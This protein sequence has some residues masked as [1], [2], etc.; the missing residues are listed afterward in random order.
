MKRTSLGDLLKEHEVGKVE[1]E[2]KVEV[3]NRFGELCREYEEVLEARDYK[4]KIK[5]IDDIL[6]PSDINTFLQTTITCQQH[7][8]YNWR[9]GMFI[10]QLIQKSYDAGNNGFELNT[11]KVKRLN[12]L[13][14]QIQG[15]KRRKIKLK[16]EGDAG[17]YCGRNSTDSTTT[18]GGNAGDYCGFDSKNS[19]ITI[20]ENAGNWCGYY[21]TD[22]TITIGGNTGNDCGWNSTDSTITIGGNA[23]NYCGWDSNNS[24]FKIKNKELYER[25][26]EEL[27]FKKGNRLFLLSPDGTEID[28]K[29]Y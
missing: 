16:I 13:G 7:Q 4:G 14:Y 27:N 21:S 1:V 25:L 9:T 10:S 18:I 12:N 29:Y 15:T 11:Q 19:I 17:D 5:T 24:T 8:N 26:K 20:G 22:S 28:P 6:A 23:G 3:K 2:R